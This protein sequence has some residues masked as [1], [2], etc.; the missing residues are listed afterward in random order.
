MP[1]ADSARLASVRLVRVAARRSGWI[2]AGKTEVFM[3]LSVG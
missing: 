1:S 3:A 2:C